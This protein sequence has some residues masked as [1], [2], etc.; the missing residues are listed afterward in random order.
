MIAVLAK[1]VDQIAPDD[2]Q[3][4]I[5]S[6]VPEGEQIDFKEALSTKGDSLDRW[7]THGDRI[8]DRA[9]NEI[10]EEVVAIANAYGGAVL[11]GI[12]ESQ[13]MPAVADEAS[14]IPQCAELAE[15][16][17]HVFRDRVEPQ[18]PRIENF[19]VPLTS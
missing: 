19:A 1:P 9:R 13:A 5:D 2:I 10:L 14:P 3:E 4:L 15:R 17:N 8:G 11:L 18:I 16:L 6:E 7:V 12:A